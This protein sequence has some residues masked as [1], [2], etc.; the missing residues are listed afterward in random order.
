ML[1]SAHQPQMIGPSALHEAQVIGVIDDAGKI[2]VFVIDAD[3]HVVPA[4]ADLAV[5]R[6]SHFDLR[7]AC[8]RAC[9][10][11]SF[12][13]QGT[14]RPA[15]TSAIPSSMAALSARIFLAVSTFE[16]IEYC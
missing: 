10:R 4:V 16:V 11:N 15:S 1:F 2:G 9:L 3:L 5:E 8:S 7:I 14:T 13:S 6:G 12:K